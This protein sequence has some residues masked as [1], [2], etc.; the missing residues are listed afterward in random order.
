MDEF[1]ANIRSVLIT[2]PA[3]WLSL[4]QTL[5]SELLE[6]KP[7]PGEWSAVECLSHLIDTDRVFNFRIQCFL[8]GED[9]PAFNPNVEGSPVSAR[10]IQDLAAEFSTLRTTSLK[11]LE[12]LSAADLDRR[13]RHAEL[14]P[15][16]LRQMLNE[17]AAHDLMHT[18]QAERALMQ[19]LIDEAGPW[20]RYFLDHWVER[21]GVNHRR[22]K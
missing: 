7:E 4:A 15:V 11:S 22:E 19:P 14:G 9:F 10:S 8:T 16:T 2:T 5:P 17:W 6:R 1:L 3:R 13:A 20:Q 18:V 12:T 21:P